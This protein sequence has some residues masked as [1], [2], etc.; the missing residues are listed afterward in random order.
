MR[1][2]QN[3][4]KTQAAYW[5]ADFISTTK[6]IVIWIDSAKNGEILPLL[7]LGKP[8]NII[9]PKGCDVKIKEWNKEEHKYILIEN[10]PTVVT[11][12]DA[13]SAWWAVKKDHINIFC[14][15]IQFTSED[16]A[17]I[18]MGELFKTMSDWLKSNRMPHILPFCL[19]G[20]ESH[21]IIAGEKVTSNQHRRTL[22]E[23]ISELTLENRAYGARLALM[24]QSHK[25]LPPASR[26]N[27]IN[28]IIKR[29]CKVSPDENSVLAQY[30]KWTN[31]YS[32]SQSV[33]VYSDGSAYPANNFGIGYPWDLPFYPKPKYKV[34]YTG[35]FDDP[36]NSTSM[37][38]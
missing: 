2:S 14:F 36:R 29:G 16:R 32:P 10:H 20:D 7:T 6:E 3:R 12:S 5:V 31:N 17:R 21:W 18:W 37:C 9:C 38:H 33:F 30:N 15:R 22:A 8:I 4:G 13:G 26:E 19:F 27:M 28:T 25:S 23:I 11:V 24:M 34:E 35:E 1:P